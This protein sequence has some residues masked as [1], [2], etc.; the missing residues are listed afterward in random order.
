MFSREDDQVL[1]MLTSLRVESEVVVSDMY[2]VC[3]FPDVFPEYIYDLSLK[4]EVDFVIDLIP[5]IRLVSMTPDKIFES[6]L[7]EL[8]KHLQIKPGFF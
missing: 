2:V 8:K 6:E 4:R 5:G 1:T 3:E 7:D